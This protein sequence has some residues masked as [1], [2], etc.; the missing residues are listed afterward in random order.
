MESQQP[1]NEINKP[2]T[3]AENFAAK[4]PL[5]ATFLRWGKCPFPFYLLRLNLFK[6][7]SMEE[8]IKRVDALKQMDLKDYFSIQFY[9]QNGEVVSVF[10]AKSIGMPKN[11]YA[12]RYRNIQPYDQNGE[13]IG[14]PYHVSIDNIRMFNGVKV[15]I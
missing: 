2:K 14:H 8:T 13:K 12:G 3:Y 1:N 15:V 7:S 6:I 10:R 9:L 5:R 4:K 11:Y